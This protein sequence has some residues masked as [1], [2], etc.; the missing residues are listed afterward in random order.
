MEGLGRQRCRKRQT[1]SELWTQITPLPIFADGN[2]IC[3]AV[4]MNSFM[5]KLNSCINSNSFIRESISIFEVMPLCFAL[6]KNESIQLLLLI[7][8]IKDSPHWVPRGRVSGNAFPEGLW[9]HPLTALLERPYRCSTHW[10]TAQ[11]ALR[12]PGGHGASSA[13]WLPANVAA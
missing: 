2:A 11:S 13:C 4:F 10:H 6:I 7:A 8:S 9:C 1:R 3:F 12:C 5:H